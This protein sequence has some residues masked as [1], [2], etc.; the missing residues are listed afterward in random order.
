MPHY[1]TIKSTLSFLSCTCCEEKSDILSMKICRSWGGCDTEHKNEMGIWE[2]NLVH[3]CSSTFKKE[4][5]FLYAVSIPNGNTFG[6]SSFDT[7]A[8]SSSPFH[9]SFDGLSQCN[10]FNWGYLDFLRGFSEGLL[11]SKERESYL[12]SHRR[13]S[14]VRSSKRIRSIQKVNII[15]K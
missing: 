10:F 7:G 11:L 1:S 9:R 13:G 8:V 6:S 2:D 4:A 3:L 14:S 12:L 15:F 5:S